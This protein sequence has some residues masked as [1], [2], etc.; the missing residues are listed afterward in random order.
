MHTFLDPVTDL[1]VSAHPAL[2]A[3]FAALVAISVFSLLNGASA[4]L[5]LLFSSAGD[6][7]EQAR[8]L[9]KHAFTLT[10]A[11][12]AGLAAVVLQDRLKSGAIAAVDALSTFTSW[13][14]DERAWW[15]LLPLFALAAALNLSALYVADRRMRRQALDAGG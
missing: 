5:H 4:L 1:I 9:S 14:F 2:T 15:V 11:G 10:A 13:A 12:V 8:Q 3:L 7:R 6:S